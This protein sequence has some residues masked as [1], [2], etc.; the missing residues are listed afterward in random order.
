MYVGTHGHSH[1]GGH[2]KE[3]LLGGSGFGALRGIGVGENACRGVHM[4]ASTMSCQN[5]SHSK[6]NTTTVHK[7]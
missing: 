6:L 4:C 2:G 5:K 3:L 1:V 7:A